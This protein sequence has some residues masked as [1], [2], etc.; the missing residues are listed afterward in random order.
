MKISNKIIVRISVL[1]CTLFMQI[2]ILS[3]G[4]GNNSFVFNGVDSRLYVLDNQPVNP[5]T[6]NQNGFQYF[7]KT[8][9]TNKT[10]SVQAWIYLIGDNAN[11]KMPII[12]RSVNPSGTSFSLYVENNKG[13]F[14]VGNSAPVSTPKFP[15]FQWI[16]LTG[17][18]DGTT[19][20]IYFGK[21]LVQSSN[22]T[23]NNPYTTG[24][25]LFVGKS[26]EGAFKGL[27]DEIRIFNT[28]IGE[29]NINGSGGNGNPAE[30]FPTSLSQYS[31][32][33][34]SFTEISNNSY[35]ADLSSSLNHLRVENINQIFPS[36]NL[37]FFVVNSTL[38]DPDAFIGDGNAASSNG[39]VTLRSAI[40]EANYSSGTN[41]IYF[42]IPGS[43]PFNIIPNSALP[44]IIN[45]VYLDGTTQSGYSGSPIV[46]TNGAF[47]GLII[48]SGNSTVQALSLNST[49]DFGLTLSSLGGNNIISNQISGISISSTSNNVDGNTIASSVS[50]GIAFLTGGN[51]NLIGSFSSNNINNNSGYGI[52][53]AGSN[54]NQINENNITSNSLGGVLFNNAS[55]TL[56]TNSITGN[57]GPGITFNNSTGVQLN[58]NTVSSNSPGGI[59]INNSTVSLSENNRGFYRKA[60][61]CNRW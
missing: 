49:S 43:G 25:G 52:S 17:I 31:V 57:S 27:I 35:L 11:V 38:D 55:S 54:G 12:Y 20:K 29:N 26:D 3:Q 13:Y 4:A 59:L 5:T 28:A 33:Q 40:Q 47:G 19:L 2:P 1:L 21:D 6:A 36:K 37:P 9:S 32:G 14:T 8:G 48:S 60:G 18:Y 56:T 50:D 58:D 34:W 46:S 16:Q 61:I 24:V 7:N 23:L 45:P 22:V 51:N 39:N 53:V 10:I 15:A 41:I 30:N 42:Y 44:T